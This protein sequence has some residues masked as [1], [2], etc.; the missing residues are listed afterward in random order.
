MK[1]DKLFAGVV[2]MAAACGLPVSRVAAQGTAFTYQGRLNEQGVAANGNYDLT[3]ALYDASSGGIAVGLPLTNAAVGV[4]NA[5]F[6][7]TLDFEPG[8]FPNANRWL[9]LRVGTDG[10]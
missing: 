8:V 7:I 6:T 3:F 1:L 5:L 4:S 10:S 9:E 2:I